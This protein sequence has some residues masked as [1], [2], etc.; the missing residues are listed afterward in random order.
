MALAVVLLGIPATATAQY[1][2]WESAE[3]QGSLD[4]E[5]PPTER[6]LEQRAEDGDEE[7]SDDADDDGDDNLSLD[8]GSSEAGG[9]LVGWAELALFVGTFD[10]EQLLR[11]DVGGISPIVGGRYSIT[12]RIRVGLEAG[13]A[14]AIH[15][16]WTD[17]GGAERDAGAAFVFANPLLSIDYG[18][19]DQPLRWRVGAG[20]TIP[21]ASATALS[22]QAALAIA[23]ASRGGWDIWMW[24]PD[25]M[26]GIL[27]GRLETDLT[28]ALVVGVD[29]GAGV[30]GYIGDSITAE[31]G[32]AAQV[33]ADIELALGQV[34]V[35]LRATGVFVGEDLFPER[36]SLQVALM[37]Y[38]LFRLSTTT[39]LT[40]GFVL[41]LDPPFGFSFREGNV[42]GLRVGIG[43]ALL[44]GPGDS[45]SS[46][47]PAEPAEDAPAD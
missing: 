35:G 47:P 2:D 1:Q 30:L 39:F 38:A 33:G 43:S 16:S 27:D 9:T 41:N 15:S 34:N 23:V 11:F 45:S 31:T 7:E 12:D 22:S 18:V 10:Y 5:P 4:Q 25:R 20:V 42:W 36:D 19:Q 21:L 17:T 24:A 28:D 29:G 44:G 6:E 13:L 37:P 32:F 14:L 8:L 40:A 26:S 3:Q 46:E